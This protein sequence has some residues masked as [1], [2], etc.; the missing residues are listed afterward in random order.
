MMK[1]FAKRAIS[2]MLVICFSICGM[3]VLNANT[4]S[5]I[6]VPEGKYYTEAVKYVTEKGYFSGTGNGRFSPD[7]KMTRAMF[8][9][10]LAAV[11]GENTELYSGNAFTDVS[12][13]S[14]YAKSVG[15]AVNAGIASGT[16]NGLFSPA[17]SITRQEV[18]VMLVKFCEYMKSVLRENVSEKVIF[19]DDDSIAS[20]A[21]NAVYTNYSWGTV[22]GN[23]GNV[24][25]PKGNA[26]RAQIAV[27]IR[28]LDLA[29]EESYKINL[30]NIDVKIE[31]LTESYSFIHISDLHMTLTD[32]TD[33]AE[34]KENQLTRGSMFF[35]DTP[36]SVK[37]HDRLCDILDFANEKKVKFVA[38]T[39]DI[40]DAPSNGNISFLANALKTRNITSLYTL[41]NH[42]WTGDWLGGYQS[43]AQRNLNIPKF[44]ESG[45]ILNGEDGY[46]V[47]DYGDFVILSV[48]NSNDQINST[49]Y[50]VL[51]RY[52]MQEKPIIL[53][54]HVPIDA[55]TLQAD[56][57]A[58]WNRCILMGNDDLNPSNYTK[59]FVNLVKSKDSTVVAVFAGHIHMDHE[60]RLS[61]EN[62]AV[63]YTLGASYKGNTALVSI[64]G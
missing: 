62:D 32:D 44:I 55:P 11:S 59:M 56:T 54:L 9:T 6:D 39:G 48:D 24:F 28:K 60:D 29:M 35:K 25:N 52:I 31:G 3:L 19:S 1:I 36:D 50:S 17:K 51:Q 47:R 2:L 26:T 8:V 37:P 12:E 13:G 34:A 53:M 23:P 16:G 33:S 7:A 22:S 40:I 64:H 38:M 27:M 43:T 20:W 4:S 14:W 42:D 10:V 61:E 41:G 15:W 58:M 30:K 57:A 18:C 5:F 45:L 49:Q 46:A 63:Q 21:K